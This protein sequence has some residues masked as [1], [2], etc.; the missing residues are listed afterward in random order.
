VRIVRPVSSS[1]RHARAVSSVETSF[2]GWSASSASG[3]TVELGPGGG[4]GIDLAGAVMTLTVRAPDGR[5]WHSDVP[6]DAPDGFEIR[7]ES[8]AGAYRGE[9]LDV[10]GRGLAGVRVRATAVNSKDD[11]FGRT[12]ASATTDA[13]GRFE[14][15]GL[16]ASSH[17]LAFQPEG[18]SPR[19]QAI[20][21]AGFR[22]SE[23]P[24]PEGTWISIRATNGTKPSV[25]R[26]SL[27][28]SSGASLTAARIQMRLDDP[29]TSGTLR[30]WSSVFTGADGS[31][32]LAFAPTADMTLF[33]YRERLSGSA[34]LERPLSA[35]ELGSPLQLVID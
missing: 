24:V 10:D 15:R 34:A 14:I 25:L 1:P 21:G 32:E 8:G 23:P 18:G 27:R 3:E 33:V 9:L 5:W 26:G 12:T 19:S 16:A 35:S 31:F 17:W 22:T 6:D 7:L 20:H 2:E 30:R 13:N 4:I 29:Q 11:E 28:D